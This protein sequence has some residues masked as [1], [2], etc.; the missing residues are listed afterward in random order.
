MGKDK[1]DLQNKDKRVCM[2]CVWT[3]VNL[4]AFQNTNFDSGL[5]IR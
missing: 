2:P 5:N 1:N 3:E 4:C